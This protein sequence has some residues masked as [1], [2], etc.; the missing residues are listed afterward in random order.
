M[1]IVGLFCLFFALAAL[2]LVVLYALQRREL[3]ALQGLS[4]Q[5]QRIAIGGRLSGRVDVAT[6]HPDLGALVTA[7]NHLL[8]RASAPAP[9]T[10]GNGNGHG[11]FSDVGDRVHEVVLIHG[12]SIL[13]A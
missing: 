9:V 12:D 11:L 2:L 4:Q 7:I 1:S 5:L 10:N 13:Y 6:D 3:R 8:A